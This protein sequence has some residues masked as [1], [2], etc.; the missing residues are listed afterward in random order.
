MRM[1]LLC[2]FARMHGYDYLRKVIQPVLQEMRELAST[3][4]FLLDPDKASE[5]E[6]EQNQKVIKVFAQGFVNIVS[7]SFSIMPL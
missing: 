6:I 4:T 3:N 2:A 5:D 7:G 1:K